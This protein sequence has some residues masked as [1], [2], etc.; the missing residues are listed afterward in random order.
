MCAAFILGLVLGF[1]FSPSDKNDELPYGGYK[2]R[3]YSLA[4][5]K[6]RQLVSGEYEAVAYVASLDVPKTP[7]SCPK[8]VQCKPCPVPTAV[9]TEE[10]PF[11]SNSVLSPQK[12]IRATLSINQATLEVSKSY[13]FMLRVNYFPDGSSLFNILTAVPFKL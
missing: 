8:G 3:G 11:S 12:E 2:F 9:L 13:K 4:A 5:L 7:C 10:N 6:A 1:A